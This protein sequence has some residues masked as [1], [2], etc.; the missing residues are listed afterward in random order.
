M[1]KLLLL[2]AALFC[3]E[4][5]MELNAQNRQGA[6]SGAQKILIVYFSRSGNTRGIARQ[7]QQKISGGLNSVELVEIECVTPYSS[8]YNTCLDEALRDQRANARPA[9]KTRISNMAQ[10]DVIMLGYPIW[11]A[12]IPAPIASF[13]EAYDFSG[14]TIIPFC[15]SGGSRFGQSLTAIAKLAPR[16]KLGEGLS[17]QYSGGASLAG[18]I[19][20]W[21][22]KNGIAER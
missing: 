21:L 14:K 7:I 8:D 6:A 17:V 18:D 5:D 11:W 9:L 2:M 19:S 22:K 4:A 12:S 10:Y 15:S 13:L 1:K 16:A 20:E 3:M